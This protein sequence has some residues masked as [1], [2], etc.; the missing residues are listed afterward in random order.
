MSI[1]QVKDPLVLDGEHR[2]ALH[3]ICGI[4]PHLAA[5]GKVHGFSQ[6]VMETWGIYSSYGRDGPSK[7]W[8][9][10]RRQD[11]CLITRDTW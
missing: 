10:Q 3:A 5:R 4:G 11:S 7:L 2:I 1:K 6:V 8:F 9:A